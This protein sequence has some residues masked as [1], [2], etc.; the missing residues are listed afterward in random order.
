MATAETCQSN[1]V[2]FTQKDLIF[3]AFRASLTL[4]SGVQ[5]GYARIIFN[6]LEVP[7]QLHPESMCGQELIRNAYWSELGLLRSDKVQAVEKFTF[8]VGQS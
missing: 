7:N 1:H 3:A 2:W 6:K 4:E 5:T 8:R